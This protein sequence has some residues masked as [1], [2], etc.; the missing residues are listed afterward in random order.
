MESKGFIWFMVLFII[1]FSG[2]TSSPLKA[3]KEVFYKY[4][5]KEL[6]FTNGSPPAWLTAQPGPYRRCNC[7]KKER[8]FLYPYTIGKNG[9]E[10]YLLLPGT[11]YGVFDRHYNREGGPLEE[12]IKM[13]IRSNG[14]IR[15]SGR[16]FLPG[17]EEDGFVRLDFEIP[18]AKPIAK[19]KENQKTLRN[20]FF[21]AKMSHYKRLFRLGIPGAAWFRHQR[22][23]ARK[24]IKE[25]KAKPDPEDRFRRRQER[26]WE[27]ELERTYSLFSGGRALSENL[28]LNR[29]LRIPESSEET[30]PM[31][32]LEGIDTLPM[33]WKK[34]VAG[35]SPKKDFLAAYIPFD[36]YALFF[37]T[38]EAMIR[39]TDEMDSRGTPVL[40]LLEPRSEDAMTRERYQKQLC[41]PMS[42]LSRIFGPHLIQSVAFTGSDPYLRTGSDVAI[43][44][45]TSNPGILKTTIGLRYSSALSSGKDC[46]EDN[47][48]IRGVTYRGVVTADRGICSYMAQLGENVV[49]VTNSKF[50]LERLVQA[51]AKDIEVINS[52][53]EYTFFRDRYKKGEDK[54]VALLVI[55]DAVI[56]KWC[57]PKWRIG[58]SRRTR[59]A[60]AMM[61]TQAKNL[62]LLA[63]GKTKRV[64]SP[65]YGN[66]DFLTPIA[67]LDIQK[68][69]KEEA[70]AY[71]WFRDHY[72]R[73][74]RQFFDPIA[75]RFSLDS[76]LIAVD[77]TVRPL[78]IDTSYG[79][80]MGICGRTATTAEAGDPHQESLI[81]YLCALDRESKP[82]RGIGGFL[83]QMV[84]QV[85]NNALN[86]IGNWFSI[87]MD[88][89]PF[90]KELEKAKKEGGGKGAWKYVE[91]NFNRFPMAL[92]VDVSNSLKLSLFLSGLRAFIQQTGPGLTTWESLTYK[93][94]P[95]VCI[96]ENRPRRPGHDE[97][98]LKIYYAPS[99]KAFVLTLSEKVLK[100]FL[101]RQATGTK[102]GSAPVK[103]AAVSTPWLGKSMNLTARDP[104]LSVLR[105]LYGSKMQRAFLR[106]S[107]GN[108][109]I[110]NEWR[111]KFGAKSAVRFHRD[112]WHTRLLCPG[113]GEYKWNE[114]FQTYESTVFGHPGQPKECD[115]LKDPLYE[116]VE[117][118]F[119]LTFEENGLRA[120]GKLTR[121]DKAKK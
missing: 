76:N 101:E 29:R 15:P 5:L 10:I 90:W 1:I 102:A 48:N 77:L 51:A 65:V 100:G 19:P 26:F 60:A 112:Y 95:Y 46:M 93:G 98:T 87:Y 74:W 43:M 121:R 8:D 34:E 30:V 68:V 92:V 107:W 73:E 40:Q 113:G 96:S 16:L 109:P 44:F 70:R 118:S 9:E 12:K 99:P 63:K 86:W 82:M 53:D 97:P 83:S 81:H 75:V 36:Q 49:V 66:L 55:S 27:W 7:F 62:A 59:A 64:S 116:I 3:E 35:L 84:P 119:G 88:K 2:F 18:K 45:K 67:E 85:G 24:E 120:I 50:Q 110:L 105:T 32:S 14:K 17:D 6:K 72:Q 91:K 31:A 104:V 80:I 78:I 57:S 103:S 38:F 71:K 11:R 114:K 117:A 28:Q 23:S 56:R 52:L 13:F 39:L 115:I 106:Q 108:I 41:M 79:G 89:D 4:T 42:K 58:D 94:Q 61:D 21:K 22:Q 20:D 111:R 47:G 69:S 33:D 37:P 54:E 25:E